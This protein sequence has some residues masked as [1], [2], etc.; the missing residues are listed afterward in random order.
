MLLKVTRIVE[1][2]KIDSAQQ[3]QLS[4]ALAQMVGEEQFTAYLASLKSKAKIS[5]NKDAFEKKER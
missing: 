5:L 3:K 4:E 1:P 2:Q